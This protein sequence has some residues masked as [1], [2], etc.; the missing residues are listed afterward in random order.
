[1]TEPNFPQ[2]PAL[3]QMTKRNFPQS[4]V[5]LQMT[6]QN[7]PQSPVL[8]QMTEPNFPQSPVL[9]HLTTCFALIPSTPYPLPDVINVVLL[10]GEGLGYGGLAVAQCHMANALVVALY[11]QPFKDGL[12]EF[13]LE[14]LAG[15]VNPHAP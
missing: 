6:K 14:F 4:P 12:A 9:C 15:A 8:L 7:F 2:S 13:A 1:M 10:A 5:L 11:A 3:L